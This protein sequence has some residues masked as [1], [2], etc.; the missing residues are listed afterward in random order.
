MTQICALKCN[1]GIVLGSD[2]QASVNTSG[3][4]IRHQLQKIHQIGDNTIFA[5]SGTIGLIQKSID[6]VRERYKLLDAGLS[7]E[8]LEDI[9]SHMFN[10]VKRAKDTYIQYSGKEEGIPIVDMLICGLDNDRKARIWHMSADT[11]DEFIDVAGCYCAGV[12][13]TF[14]YALMKSLMP[15]SLDVTAGELVIYRTLR[16][17]INSLASGVGEPIDIWRMKNGGEIMRSTEERINAF[18]RAYAKW[19]ITDSE[20]LLTASKRLLRG[21]D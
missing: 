18:Y 4:T 2:G 6:V 12:G 17:T 16:D 8:V 13:E 3:G 19:K 10:I 7:L 20:F 14:G 15:T 21:R 11:H 5:A 1:D 9:K